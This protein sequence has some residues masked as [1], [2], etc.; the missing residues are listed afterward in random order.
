MNRLMF[1]IRFAMVGVLCF[2][3][4]S[5]YAEDLLMVRSSQP[6]P[7]AMLSLETGIKDH[8][9]TV[10]RV[11]RVDVGLK[12]YGFRTDKYRIVF[13]GKKAEIQQLDKRYPRLIPYLP[14]NF[15]IFAEGDDTIIT[16][17][18]PASLKSYYPDP[19]LKPVFTQWEMDI[20]GILDSL[21]VR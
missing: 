6:F 1:T 5:V 3:A 19:E 8:G 13:F 21:R 14:L 12:K 9:Y 20:R 2:G 10:T 15:T 16:A 11:Q 4:V 17:V 18:N 7:E